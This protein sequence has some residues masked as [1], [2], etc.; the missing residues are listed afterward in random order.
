MVCWRRLCVDGKLAEALQ[1]AVALE[2]QFHESYVS[3]EAL[4]RLYVALDET[5]V[6]MQHLD[7]AYRMRVDTLNSIK[8]EPL[9]R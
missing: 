3:P 7:E 8:V 1:I 9:L 4:A 6:A 2:A 5:D